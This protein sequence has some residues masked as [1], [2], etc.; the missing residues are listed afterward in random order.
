M[1]DA[2]AER[3]HFVLPIV[4]CMNIAYVF[5]M[6]LGLGTAA[7]ILYLLRRDALSVGYSLWW[8]AVAFGLIGLSL[9]PFLVDALGRILGIHYPPIILLI[10]ALCVVLIKLL[11]MDIDRSQQERNIRV[12]F[13]RLAILEH[14]LELRS[15]YC[16]LSPD[17]TA[18]ENT[19]QKRS[20]D[21]GEVEGHQ[22]IG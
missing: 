19:E 7:V 13:Q 6:T 18:D 4:D 20:Q 15:Y 14:A 3:R 12:L 17:D 16:E 10:I 11:F 22:K 2:G 9:F 5:S 8:L 21:Q 1:Q